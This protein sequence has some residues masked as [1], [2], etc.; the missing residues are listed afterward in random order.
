[1]KLFA[2]AASALTIAVGLCALPAASFAAAIF[3][4]FNIDGTVTVTPSTISWTDNAGVSGKTT[5]ASSGLSGSFTG[6][7]NTEVSIF[8]LTNPPDAVN[9]TFTPTAFINFASGLPN[10]LIDFINLGS[11]TASNCAA[12]PAVAGQTCTPPN[13]GGSPFGFTNLGTPGGTPTGSSGAFSFSGVTSDGL[14]TWTGNFTSQFGTPFQTVLQGL[15]S[16]GSVTNT[17]SGTITL[18]AITTVPEPTT[19]VLMLGFL[20]VLCG[21]RRKVGL[22]R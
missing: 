7:G 9:S 20:L 2:P 15:A 14:A 11:Y 10:L 18:T 13:P 17:Y 19:I 22:H 3:G 5:I 12:S 6:L 16:T 1:M 21:T 8:S 4:S